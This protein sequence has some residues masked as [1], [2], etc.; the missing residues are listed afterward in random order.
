MTQAQHGRGLV[1][2]DRRHDAALAA[3][4]DGLESLLL[5]LVEQNGNQCSAID[6]DHTAFRSSMISRGERRSRIDMVAISRTISSMR[7][8]RALTA[9]GDWSRC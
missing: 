3:C 8:R 7:A 2:I 1:H 6:N 5:R 4:N 9:P